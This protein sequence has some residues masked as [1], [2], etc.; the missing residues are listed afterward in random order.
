ML[1]AAVSAW[2]LFDVTCAVIFFYMRKTNP[3]LR[4]RG[5]PRTFIETRGERAENVYMLLS[6]T[7]Q[8]A[9]CGRLW[10]VW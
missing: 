9:V 6:F 7:L 8:S 4:G 5:Y 3:R 2:L 10:G 1:A